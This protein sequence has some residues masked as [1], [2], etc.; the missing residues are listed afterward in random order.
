MSEESLLSIRM[1]KMSDSELKNY[2]D[3]KDHFQEYAVL[4]ALLELEKRGVIIENS[5]QIKQDAKAIEIAEIDTPEYVESSATGVPE[6]YSTRFILIFGV[7]TL[8]GGSILMAL[9]F[10]QLNNKKAAR[11]VIVAS[12][13]YSLLTALIL[14][15]FGIT[16]TFI[17]VAIGLL[18]IYLLYDLIYK[19]EFPQDI[20]NFKSRNIWTPILICLLISIPLLYLL[21]ATGN[22]P[23]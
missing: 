11:L 22:L 5:D 8:L 15:S 9:N 10:I 3:N 23:Q 16:N 14:Q 2:T 18:G 6:L 19:K 1:A 17:S 12:L 7:F 13:V 20:K 21:A 4:S